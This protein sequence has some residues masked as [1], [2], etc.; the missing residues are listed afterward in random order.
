MT[1]AAGSIKTLQLAQANV[2]LRPKNAVQI[3]SRISATSRLTQLLQQLAYYSKNQL[4]L[5]CFS[6]E[7]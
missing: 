4:R 3:T 1:H 7:V 6:Q 5:K 2:N